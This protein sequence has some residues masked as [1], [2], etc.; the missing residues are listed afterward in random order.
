[1][2][3]SEH[4]S[5]QPGPDVLLSRLG[6]K[7]L[8]MSENVRA[9]EYTLSGL[10]KPR[11]GGLDP[12]GAM[13]SPSDMQAIQSLDRLRQELG[14]LASFAEGL[15]DCDCSSKHDVEKLH[16]RFSLRDLG[17][18]IIRGVSAPS[19]FAADDEDD[20]EIL[21]KLHSPGL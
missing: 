13:L 17:D 9:L 1:M 11:S 7:L 21:M 10:V 20:V 18:H 4:A 8:A 15:A 16:S 5:A 3:I 19:H 2:R 14:D 12:H 6:S